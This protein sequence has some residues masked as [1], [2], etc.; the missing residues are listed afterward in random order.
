V[1]TASFWGALALVARSRNLEVGAALARE[2]AGHGARS[3][4]LAAACALGAY[5]L[6][7][8]L[9]STLATLGVLFVYTVGGEALW[10]SL[11][12]ARSSQWSLSANVQ[13]WLLDGFR[14]YDESVCSPGQRCDPTYVLSASQG[15]VHLGVLLLVAIVLSLVLFPRRDV[16]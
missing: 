1:V 4:A 14:V 5:A 8:A 12:L 7:M 10:A 3:V 6:T 9:R 11:P 2:I 13:A 16:P 15:A